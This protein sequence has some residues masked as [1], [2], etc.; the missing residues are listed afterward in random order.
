MKILIVDDD[1]LILELVKQTLALSG[2]TDVTVA[3]SAIDASQIIAGASP[4]F[5]CF[6]FDMSMPEIEGD[7]LCYWVRQLPQYTATPILMVTALANKLDIDRAF[8]AGA[9]DYITKPIDISDFGSRMKQVERKILQSGFKAPT[10]L[11]LVG[12]HP[13]TVDRV[14][15]NGAMRIGGIA[16]EINLVALEKYLFQLSRAGIDGLSAFAF[17]IQDAAKFHFVCSKDEYTNVLRPVGETISKRLLAPGYF[18]SHSGCG[19]FVG[20][21]Q[22]V[23]IERI[24]WEKIE[25]DVQN[26]VGTIAIPSRSGLP[27]RIEVHSA[28][29]QRLNSRSGEKSTDIL[30]RT[31]VEA[32]ERCRPISAVA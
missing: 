10:G 18:L 16:G 2:F 3:R 7:T 5:E 13:K 32:E 20:V 27:M 11:H 21:V 29:P 6:L 28:V 15:F 17:S 23:G 8:A 1:P 22:Q 19:S 31:I 12:Q 26:S 4:A 30:Y 9:S 24:E 14:E 25:S